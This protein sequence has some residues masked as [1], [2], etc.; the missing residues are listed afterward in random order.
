MKG[1]VEAGMEFRY[2]SENINISNSA[3][4]GLPA[5]AKTPL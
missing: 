3:A 4:S 1:E 2:W 5:P